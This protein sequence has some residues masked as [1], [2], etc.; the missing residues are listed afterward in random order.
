MEEEDT[1]VSK[2]LIL[3]TEEAMRSK[4]VALGNKHKDIQLGRKNDK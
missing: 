1:T 2:K 3:W 4:K